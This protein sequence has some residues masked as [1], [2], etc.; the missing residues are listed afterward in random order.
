MYFDFGSDDN[1][2]NGDDDD[3]SS[4]GDYS[5]IVSNGSPSRKSKNE[6]RSK[7]TSDEGSCRLR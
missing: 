3:D 4:S 7:I 1:L 5:S 6:K 2:K